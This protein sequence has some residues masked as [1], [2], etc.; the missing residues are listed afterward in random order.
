MRKLL[1]SIW[2][3]GGKLYRSYTDGTVE[4]EYLMNRVERIQWL[5]E[6]HKQLHKECQATPSKELKKEK[7][8]IKDEIERLEYN[9][10]EHQ[11]GVESFR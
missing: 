4:K 3:C 9:P 1:V 11:G 6:R 5:K 8:S 10:D 2:R 7:L